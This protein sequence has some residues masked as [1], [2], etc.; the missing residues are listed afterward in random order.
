VLVIDPAGRVLL[1][2]GFD[3]LAGSVWQHSTKFSFDG[4]RYRRGCSTA[5]LPC[6]TAQLLRRLD[7]AR[8]LPGVRQTQIGQLA[9]GALDTAREE[10]HLGQ[11][12]SY[13]EAVTRALEGSSVN[14][15]T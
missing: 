15:S 9:R 2:E 6:R 1:L 4:T 12:V 8:P 13:G 10:L 5:V 14:A 3:P 7:G 11:P